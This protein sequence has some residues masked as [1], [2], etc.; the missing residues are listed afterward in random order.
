MHGPI[1]DA[2]VEQVTPEKAGLESAGLI[3]TLLT[4]PA[5][6]FGAE[7]PEPAR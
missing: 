3:E 7:E 6:W 1:S 2:E 4:L 5:K